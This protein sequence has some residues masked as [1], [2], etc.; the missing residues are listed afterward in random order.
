MFMKSSYT[1]CSFLFS[2]L[3]VRNGFQMYLFHLY[4]TSTNIVVPWHSILGRI[5][6]V[7]DEVIEYRQWIH[8]NWAH[9]VPPP[10]IYSRNCIINVPPPQNIIRLGGSSNTQLLS[11][12]ANP[13]LDNTVDNNMEGRNR[14][15]SEDTS[16][17]N[18]DVAQ[19]VQGTESEMNSLT[20]LAS[21]PDA[22]SSASDTVGA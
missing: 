1:Y 21:T 9:K 6:R 7:T 15:T 3:S 18:T 13:T 5:V 16:N 17:A 20:S 14:E 4:L 2:T 8:V 22:L 12:T 11:S 10:M 19:N